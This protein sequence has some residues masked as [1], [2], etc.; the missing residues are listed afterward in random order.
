MKN[1]DGEVTG[2]ILSAFSPEDMVADALRQELLAAGYKVDCGPTMPSAVG[3][4]IALAGIQ[5][6]VDEEAGIPKVDAN[7]KVKVSMDIWKEGHVLKH[8]SYESDASD[9]A[10]INRD[11]LPREIIEQGLRE[12]MRQAVSE[13]VAVLK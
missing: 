5:I 2:D 10:V 6:A 3:K 7:G 8:V 1:S 13:I 4:G 12:V 11:N 9:F